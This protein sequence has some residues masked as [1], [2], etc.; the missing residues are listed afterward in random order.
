MTTRT[1]LILW[2]AWQ[3]ISPVAIQHWDAGRHAESEKHFDVAVAEYRKVTELE[4]TFAAGFVS[5]G[6]TFMEQH[7]YAAAIAPLKHALE[8]DSTLGPAHQLV[9]Y[10]LLAQGYA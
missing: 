8:L 4:P 3:T 9:G 5:L 1:I 10:A 7:N 2:L 6:Q